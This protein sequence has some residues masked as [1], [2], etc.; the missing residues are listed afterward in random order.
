MSRRLDMPNNKMGLDFNK[1]EEKKK[2]EKEIPPAPLYREEE[3]PKEEQQRAKQ[4]DSEETAK[5]V[6]NYAGENIQEV[7]VALFENARLNYEEKVDLLG[8]IMNSI[9]ERRQALLDSLLDQ[10]E[11]RIMNEGS[12]QE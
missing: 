12:N 2:E 5:Q 3:Q 4:F 7:I 8:Q 11:S 9:K 10:Y 6:I 1:T